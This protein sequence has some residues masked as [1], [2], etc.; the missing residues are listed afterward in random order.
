M[1]NVPYIGSARGG[2]VGDAEYFS[3]Y[4]EYQGHATFSEFGES[5]F[6]EDLSR[7]V[8]EGFDTPLVSGQPAGY[9]NLYVADIEAGSYEPVTTVTPPEMEYQPFEN[10]WNGDT[11]RRPWERRAISAM[12][13]SSSAQVCAVGRRRDHTHIMRRR[14]VAL[15]RCGDR[16]R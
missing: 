12:S 2:G 13:S 7:G 4:T 14:A 3:P 11:L 8:V 9:V 1:L 6:T 15:G 5:L 16:R 10:E